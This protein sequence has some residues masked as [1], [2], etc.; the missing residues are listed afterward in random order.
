MR[1]CIETIDW[2]GGV[3]LGFARRH[4]AWAVAIVSFWI[5]HA[6]T[7]ITYVVWLDY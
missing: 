3:L 7:M 6:F 5:G 4:P 1:W 2:F